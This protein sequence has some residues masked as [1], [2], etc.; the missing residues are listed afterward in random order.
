MRN[1]LLAAAIATAPSLVAT[2]AAQVPSPAGNAAVS[3]ALGREIRDVFERSRDAI[4]KVQAADE[5]GAIAGSGFFLNEKGLL[6]TSYAVG[7]L[8]EKITVEFR[9]VAYPATKVA[10]D[11]RSGLAFLKIDATTPSLPRAKAL[12]QQVG[13]AHVLIGYPLDLSISPSFGMVAGFDNQ[14]QRQ[15]FVTAHMR[16][17]AAAERGQTGAPVLNMRGEVIGVCISILENGGG[18]FAL[19]IEAVERVYADVAEFQE[20]R[21]AWIGV[22][23]QPSKMP[24]NGTTAEI[25]NVIDESPGSFAGVEVG[26]MIVRIGTRP[27]TSPEQVMDA[28]FYARVGQPLSLGLLRA[29]ESV[30]VRMSPII[31]VTAAPHKDK[32]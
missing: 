13:D 26:D 9:G 24:V 10:A 25:K 31:R 30:E 6:L 1:L 2:L 32:K 23:I 21:H 5:D 22:Q 7:G 11:P 19:P 14:H 20:V 28:L 4:V 27:V 16:S 17:M 12:G 3:E 29:G 8:A 15:Y 18:F